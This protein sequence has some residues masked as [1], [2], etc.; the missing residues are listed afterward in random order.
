MTISAL[1]LFLYPNTETDTFRLMASVKDT[2][3]GRRET[4]QLTD[5]VKRRQQLLLGLMAPFKTHSG[6]LDKSIDRLVEN[7]VLEIRQ[8]GM[9]K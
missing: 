5:G 8:A 9:V 2:Y 3:T 1:T 4:I 6:E 7:L